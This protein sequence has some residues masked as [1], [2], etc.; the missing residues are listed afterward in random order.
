MQLEK[1]QTA[2]QAGTV[3]RSQL[4][5]AAIAAIA[6][7]GLSNVTLAKVAA[8]A[9]LTAASVNFHFTSKEALLLAI[10]RQLAEDFEAAFDYLKVDGKLSTIDLNGVAIA[11]IQGLRQMVEEKDA[12]VQSL[13]TEVEQRDRQIDDLETRLAALEARFAQNP[14]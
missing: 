2:Q 1:A 12:T 11:A 13:K 3:R 14:D 5:A 9:G 7:H 8:G 10:L 4:I 6:E